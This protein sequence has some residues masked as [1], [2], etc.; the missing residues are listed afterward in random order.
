MWG[1]KKCGRG[2]GVSVV[3]VRKCAGVWGRRSMGDVGKGKGRCEEV[4]GEVW[5]NVWGE[6]GGCGEV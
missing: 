4:W 1:V 2:Y 6:C 3:R 5:E